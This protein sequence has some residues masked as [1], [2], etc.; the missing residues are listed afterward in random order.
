MAFQRNIACPQC[1]G[2]NEIVNPAVSQFTCTFCNSVSVLADGNVHDTGKKSKLV[3]ATSGLT[4]GLSGRLRDVPFTVTGR[5]RYGYPRKNAQGEYELGGLWDE[6][7]LTSKESGSEK[8]FWLSEDMGQFILETPVDADSLPGTQPEAGYKFSFD[9]REYLVRESNTAVCAGTEGQ[10]PF[11]VIPDEKYP[12]IDA[13]ST[14][15]EK[16]V[17]IEYTEDGVEAYRGEKLA[18]SEFSYESPAYTDVQQSGASAVQCPNCGHS[19][20]KKGN[21]A[22]VLTLVCPAC[23][24]EISLDSGTA[25]KLGQVNS[26]YA[27]VFTLNLDDRFTLRDVDYM[28]VARMRY[29]WVEDGGFDLEYV[30]YNEETGYRYLS[31]AGRHYYLSWPVDTPP[32]SDMFRFYTRKSKVEIDGKTFKFFEEGDL[33]LSYID[34]ALPW[35]A[36][37]GDRVHYADAVRPPYLFTQEVSGE[38]SEYEYSMSVLLDHKEVEEALPGEHPKP[39]GVAAA[40]KNP[41]RGW[42][43]LPAFAGIIIAIGLLAFTIN[44][45]IK[46]EEVMSQGFS[47]SQLNKREAYTKTFK[48]TQPDQTMKATVNVPVNNSW[49]SV[50]VALLDDKE[51]AVVTATDTTIE[52]YHGVEDGESWSEGSQSESIYW[53]VPRAGD[54]RLLLTVPE[55][56]RISN[57]LNGNVKVETGV[58][59]VWPM[60]VAGFLWFLVPLLT[61]IK[62]KGFETRRWAW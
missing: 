28:V 62:R 12:F 48:I 13:T 42:A 21:T 43:L 23:D 14:D 41:I 20:E 54:Y 10:L 36:R 57:R 50:G 32:E 40:Q 27:E 52:Y 11:Q 26:E 47:I 6:W 35:V 17:T 25:V 15:G 58:Y 38:G 53:Q 39:Y 22:S 37:V 44:L 29:E 46:G 1:G 5:V 33:E 19:I 18:R 3:P 7:Y 61:F 45:G 9:E 2:P 16:F 4:V 59:R 8:S 31:Q 55:V 24:S 30:L 49:V 60:A 56:D 51:K 34:G